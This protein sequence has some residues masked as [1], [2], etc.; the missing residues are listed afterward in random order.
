[1][2]PRTCRRPHFY[3]K[4]LRFT[5]RASETHTQY[6]SNEEVKKLAR[7]ALTRIDEQIAELEAEEVGLMRE[8]GPRKRRA[9][10]VYGPRN[11]T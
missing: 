9:P 3:A 6:M 7:K 10:W 5:A 4:S 1:M 8:R 11:A 2:S